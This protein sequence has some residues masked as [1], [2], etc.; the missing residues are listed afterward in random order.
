LQRVGWLPL[1]QQSQQRLPGAGV[2]LPRIQGPVFIRIG[3]VKASLHHDK[4]FVDRQCA[5]MIGVGGRQLPS[6]QPARQFE[7]SVPS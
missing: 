1:F 7:S 6:A 3:C 5:V 2:E 4:I